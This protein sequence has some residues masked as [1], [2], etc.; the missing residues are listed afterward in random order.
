MLNDW[1]E[2]LKDLPASTILVTGFSAERFDYSLEQAGYLVITELLTDDDKA[3]ME[4]GALPLPLS[5]R[6]DPMRSHSSLGALLF[7]DYHLHFLPLAFF[8][9]AHD[10][11]APRGL[12]ILIIHQDQDIPTDKINHRKIDYTH[13]LAER[14]GF[15]AVDLS[16]HDIQ[17]NSAIIL[18]KSAHPP[19]WRLEQLKETDIGDFAKLFKDAFDNEIDPALWHW[20]YAE[21]R[22]HGIIARRGERLVAH[23]G[24]TRRR[25]MYFGR[26]IIALQ[27]CDVMVDPRERGVMTK[28]GAMFLTTAT[29]LELYLGLQPA[30]LPFGFPNG[31]HERL[32]EKLGLYAE[33]GRI[34]ELRWSALRDHPRLYTRI[35]HLERDHAANQKLVAKLWQAM[36]RDLHEAIV[37]I[38]DW[39]YLVYRYLDH[40]VHRYEV[41]IVSSRF[42]GTPLGL[43]ILRRLDDSVELVDLIAPLNHIHIL[44]D[45]ARR[46]TG[47]WRS[48]SLFCWI[49]QQYIRHFATP[50]VL[51]KDPD[52]SIPTN[53]WVDGPPVE[54]IKNR[55][56]LMSGDTDFH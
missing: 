34:A 51:V 56:W 41:M 49:S 39:D 40:P 19:R 33:V 31:R 21:G 30:D 13:A 10:C 55:W 6:C 11:L 47:R 38:R 12:L 44:V 50:D 1:V 4:R 17:I 37:V 15:K 2:S 48:S 5:I 35:R 23:Y 24:C 8:N 54:Q 32:G 7:F 29:M 16:T 46:L 22:G 36:S 20:K 53:I 42:T 18:R 52:I 45:Q 14:C 25:A 3:A 43:I 28:Q 9:L 27:M 26:P